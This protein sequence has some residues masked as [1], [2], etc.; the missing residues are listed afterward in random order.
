MEQ[1][2]INQKVLVAVPQLTRQDFFDHIADMWQYTWPDGAI[3]C[4]N[5]ENTKLV[6]LWGN[7]FKG[8]AEGSWTAKMGCSHTIEVN[9]KRYKLLRGRLIPALCHRST[10]IFSSLMTIKKY[11]IGQRIFVP[12]DFVP[13]I[14]RQSHTYLHLVVSLKDTI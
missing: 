11:H 6:Y 14:S 9:K 12:L 2:Q 1:N 13:I 4:I 10:L 3:E 8:T 7:R 5:P